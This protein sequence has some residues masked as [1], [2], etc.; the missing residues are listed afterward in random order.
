MLQVDQNYH[1]LLCAT[2]YAETCRKARNG[3]MSVHTAATMLNV[4]LDGGQQEAKAQRRWL[5]ARIPGQVLGWIQ[6][7]QGAHRLLTAFEAERVRDYFAVPPIALLKTLS[8]SKINF[9]ADMLDGWAATRG[10]DPVLSVRLI[11]S[12]DGYRI[13]ADAVGPDHEPPCILE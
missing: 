11:G 3:E 1:I 13:L 8:A 5:E 9:M 6:K 7:K 12:A 2:R 4:L 10:L